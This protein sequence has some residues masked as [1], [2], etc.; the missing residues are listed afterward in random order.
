MTNDLVTIELQRKDGEQIF[1]NPYRVAEFADIL[2][3]TVK[4]ALLTNEAGL[5]PV[6][7]LGSVKTGSLLLAYK[8]FLARPG[9]R[10]KREMIETT[11]LAMEAL[12]WAYSA[13]GWAGERLKLLVPQA[14][15]APYSHEL[16]VPLPPEMTTGIDR[17]LQKLAKVSID[18][19]CDT[20]KITLPDCGTYVMDFDN[21]RSA[22]VLGRLAAP[23][24]MPPLS[25]TNN[26]V[27][28]NETLKGLWRRPNG[29]EEEVELI[30]GN[31]ETHTDVV[32]VLV[33]WNSKRAPTP[34]TDLHVTGS[35]H[36]IQTADFKPTE[37]V[38]A[39]LQ[40]IPFLLVV[41]GVYAAE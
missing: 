34:R 19:E 39:S 41:D 7:Y 17:Q 22:A 1:I 3:Q 20:C 29:T 15:A 38:P 5:E 28:Q 33:K 30:A 36:P 21:I 13:I 23:R 8:I 14:P 4:A 27:L 2:E 12:L 32:P 40:T 35:L 24:N 18:A 16:T 11:M 37:L 31:L 6:A 25:H 9:V 10:E 26:L